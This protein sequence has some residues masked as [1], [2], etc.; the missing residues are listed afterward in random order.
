MLYTIFLIS[1]IPNSS[2]H[3]SKAVN[4]Y[5]LWTEVRHALLVEQISLREAAER[6][7]LNFRTVQKIRDNVSPPDYVRGSRRDP[8]KLQA[9]LPFIE[10]YLA[11]DAGMSPKQR[12]TAPQYN[13]S[14]AQ[15]Y[16]GYYDLLSKQFEVNNTDR[17][18]NNSITGES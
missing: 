11:E 4:G 14:N 8:T 2:V 3:S 9:F 10:E 13:S 1:P 6:F 17:L 18:A 7:D 15:Q 5:Q 12:H 16:M